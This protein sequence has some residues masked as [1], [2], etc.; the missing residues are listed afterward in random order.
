MKTNRPQQIDCVLIPLAK[1]R[2]R[3]IIHSQNPQSIVRQLD[4]RPEDNDWLRIAQAASS[5]EDGECDE[6]KPAQPV[7]KDHTPV[8]LPLLHM[9]QAEDV[10]QAY[11]RLSPKSIDVD[12][13]EI[14]LSPLAY[15]QF[16]S[17]A[18]ATVQL[19]SHTPRRKPLKDGADVPDFYNWLL[20][21]AS[22]HQLWMDPKYK[23]D[24]F[25]ELRK[26]RTIQPAKTKFQTTYGSVHL[27]VNVLVH[28]LTTAGCTTLRLK[29]YGQKLP[30]IDQFYKAEP[31]QPDHKMA[32]LNE[33]DIGVTYASN[34]IWLFSPKHGR[35]EGLTAYPMLIPASLDY[36][37]VLLELR[38]QRRKYK[39]KVYPRMVHVIKSFNSRLQGDIPRLV[40]VIRQRG[41]ASQEMIN[42]LSTVPAEQLG[43][44]RIEG[45]Q[46][47]LG[48]GGFCTRHFLR[49][50]IHH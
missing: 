29:A 38:H 17:S 41:K 13:W 30:L 20:L 40:K 7:S 47:G 45:L 19:A 50:T 43:G 14:A 3:P 23:E 37:S 48:G 21:A 28:C 12:K 44:F 39:V 10:H 33:W 31:A 11:L 5:S 2:K 26:W 22:G 46:G 9:T 34:N 42:H 1:P 32:D 25:K 8:Q 6:D 35:G 27:P 4:N 36:G 24:F 15:Q 18:L 49:H 16:F